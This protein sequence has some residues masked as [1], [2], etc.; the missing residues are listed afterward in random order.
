MGAVLRLDPDRIPSV[1]NEGV[2]FFDALL[3]HLS[4]ET[5]QAAASFRRSVI[6][7]RGSWTTS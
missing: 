7:E 3:S 6:T 5:V 1:A 2:R 4:Q